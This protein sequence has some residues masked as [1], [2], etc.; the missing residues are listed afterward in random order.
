MTP[1]LPFRTRCTLA[2][3]IILASL[4]L[5]ARAAD[6]LDLSQ[7]LV[8]LSTNLLVP[9]NVDDAIALFPRAEKA[10]YTG[11][12][13][14]DSKFSVLQRQPKSYAANVERL[15]KAAADHHLEIIPVLFPVGWSNNIL[16]N[17][18]NLAE[19]LP[20][21]DALFVVKNN[22]AT[23]LP[24]PPITLKSPDFANLKAWDF[25]DP[26]AAYDPAEKALC[27][28]GGAEH[29]RICQKIKVAPFRE[30]RVSLRI[31]TQD[32]KGEPTITILSTD[33][34]APQT[35]DYPQLQI[36]PTSDWKTYSLVFNS[37]QNSEI[38]LYLGAWGSKS[39]KAWL[40]DVKLEEVGLLNVLR[41]PGAPVTVKTDA[42]APRPASK[43]YAPIA[44]P[45]LGQNPWPG[46]F[47]VTHD[48]PPI[49]LLSNLPDGTR[50]RVSWYH[51][52]IIYGGSVMLCPSEPKTQQLLHDE[53][54]AV[55]KLFN[56][57][58]YFMAH[59]EIRI[60]NWCDACQSR[61]Q[62]PGQLLADNV[63]TCIK[64]LK[65]INPTGKIYVWS[66]MFDPTHN[67]HDN[68]YLV[69][70]TLA[71]S[72]KGLDKDVIIALW[73]S[74]QRDQSI[75]FFTDLGNPMIISGFYDAPVEDSAKW[76]QSAQK[77]PGKIIGTMYTTWEN[78]YRDLEPYAKLI[79]RFQ[80]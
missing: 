44:D 64:T 24:D 26:A 76:F 15:K 31:K 66:D 4:S 49:K 74:D 35:L 73:N 36:P 72:W 6:K 48:A 55:H 25:H 21:K 33:K 34:A 71:D 57:H 41:R 17:D 70:G 42:G 46:E 1:T 38:T 7:R 59:D 77:S 80:K 43:D 5:P 53:A 79:D 14:T 2:A 52:M 51:P 37:L 40:A 13:L 30:Y 9:E 39:G 62:T 16:A 20:V 8:Y 12:V 18:P 63:R 27:L 58:A 68:Y 23:L 67:A 78:N 32:F 47:E 19:G 61:H 75:K 22:Q 11:I 10:G 3:A 45:K 29:A 56:A 65:Q 50:L 54:L 28:T 69:N 60:M